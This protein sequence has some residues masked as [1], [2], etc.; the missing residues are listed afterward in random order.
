MALAK[1]VLLG[2]QFLDVTADGRDVHHAEGTGSPRSLDYLCRLPA[3]PADGAVRAKLRRVLDF[4]LEAISDRPVSY[5]VLAAIV[6]VDD[7]IPF[8]PGDTAMI[9]AGILAAN[10]ALLIG[11]VIAAGAVGG[12]LGDNLFYFLGRR[13]GRRLA[14]RLLRRPRA[15]ELYRST[16]RQIHARGVTIILVGRFVPAGRTATTFAC[17]TVEYP[18]RRFF[19]ADAA[20]ATAWAAYTALLGF[21]GGNAFRDALWEPLLIGLGIALVLGLGAEAFSRSQRSAAH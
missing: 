14:G 13:F 1:A 5:L 3:Q 17:G 9:T 7:F 11:V 19:L 21:I 20:A 8:A 4:L 12:I 10:D 2:D 18:Y 15:A 16:E 6:F